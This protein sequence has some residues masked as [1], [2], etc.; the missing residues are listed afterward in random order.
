VRSSKGNKIVKQEKTGEDGTLTFTANKLKSSKKYELRIEKRDSAFNRENVIFTTD[1]DGE[2]VS[3]DNKAVTDIVTLKNIEIGID[4][5]RI[6]DNLSVWTN[7]GYY[8]GT[9]NYR[10][11]RYNLGAS[12]RF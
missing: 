11:I 8:M 6:T 4:K 2:I 10:D 5:W 12:Y 7:V 3:I 1:K 9:H